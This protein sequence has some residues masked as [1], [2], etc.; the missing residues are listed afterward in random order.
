MW[1][2][3][4]EDNPDIDGDEMENTFVREPSPFV[5]QYID[6]WERHGRGEHCCHVCSEGRQQMSVGGSC[7]EGM[8][9]SSLS[10]ILIMMEAAVSANRR[11]LVCGDQNCCWVTCQ[12]GC[13]VPLR[14][15]E[16]EFLHMPSSL[17]V[18]LGDLEP[19]HQRRA[20]ALTVGWSGHKRIR[21]LH[22][23]WWT[24]FT[25][26]CESPQL[27]ISSKVLSKAAFL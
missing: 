24:L 2:K 9:C 19:P 25:S 15:H 1:D 4:A 17:Q 23:S 26:A 20:V 21:V 10:I 3:F 11:V 5:Q 12:Q 16:H 22:L 27:S 13:Q 14:R 6:Q 8:N 7:E 18:A